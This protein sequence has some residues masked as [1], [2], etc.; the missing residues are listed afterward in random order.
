MIY[1]SAGNFERRRTC[2]VMCIIFVL[3]YPA[4]ET[5]PKATACHNRVY[6]IPQASAPFHKGKKK[7]KCILLAKNI[8][9]FHS[10]LVTLNN[11][12]SGQGQYR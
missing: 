10:H 12:E 11:K 6:V 8:E 2:H 4:G 9:V 1:S 3:G 7:P 5:K